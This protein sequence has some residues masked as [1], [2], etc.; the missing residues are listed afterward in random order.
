MQVLLYTDE[1]S[2]IME[3][4]GEEEDTQSYW[5]SVPATERLWRA[6]WIPYDQPRVS[7]YLFAVLWSRGEIRYW[8]HRPV[9]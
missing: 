4:Y 8:Q 6:G 1:H 7:R 2:Y 5:V 3:P 9:E